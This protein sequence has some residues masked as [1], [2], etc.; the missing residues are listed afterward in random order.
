MEGP[1]HMVERTW[2]SLVLHRGSDRLAADD[3][4]KTE[5]GHQPLDRATGDGKVFAQHLPIVS[6]DVV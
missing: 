6:P 4:V 5:T 2:R 1:V 3:A